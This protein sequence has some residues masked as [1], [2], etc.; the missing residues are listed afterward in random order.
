MTIYF[1][2]WKAYLGC[3]EFRLGAADEEVAGA[4]TGLGDSDYEE[5]EEV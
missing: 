3:D 5:S 4:F 1:I 2:G